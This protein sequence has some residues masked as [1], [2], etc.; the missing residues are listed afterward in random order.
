MRGHSLTNLQELRAITTHHATPPDTYTMTLITID[1]QLVTP[2]PKTGVYQHH[3]M[4]DQGAVHTP[5]VPHSC[6]PAR[7]TMNPYLTLA[8]STDTLFMTDCA[9]TGSFIW[10]GTMPSQR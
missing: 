2:P 3:P 7:P 9:H 10:S 6:R 5:P 4:P 1:K 8:L